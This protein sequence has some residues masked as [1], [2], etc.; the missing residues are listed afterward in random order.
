MSDFT[1]NTMQR[2]YNNFGY[3]VDP[4]AEHGNQYVGDYNKLA[5]LGGT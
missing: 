1:F 4:N 2:T 3:T 5:T